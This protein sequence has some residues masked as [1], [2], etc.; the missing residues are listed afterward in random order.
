MNIEEL[1]P[2]IKPHTFYW[3]D[4]EEL[5]SAN[6]GTYYTIIFFVLLQ[7]TGGFE[8]YINYSKAKHS[9]GFIIDY[10]RFKSIVNNCKINAMK[11][12]DEEL[13]NEPIQKLCDIMLELN[14]EYIVFDFHGEL[15]DV[16]KQSIEKIECMCSLCVQ[17]KNGYGDQEGIIF[18]ELKCM[19]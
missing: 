17:H 19:Q 18:G 14:T 16:Q 8:D 11:I 9:W 1:L 3:F 15:I 2:K 13:L 4:G 12:L 7:Y 6:Y 5:N 10:A